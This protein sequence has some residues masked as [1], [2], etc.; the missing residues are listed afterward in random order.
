MAGEIL[1]FDTPEFI[2][3]TAHGFL[4]SEPVLNNLILTLL[5][6]RIAFPEPVRYW[7]ARSDSAVTGVGLQSPPSFALIL[8]VMA[9]EVSADLAEAIAVEGRALPGVLADARVAARFAGQW[10]ECR[11]VGVQPV[12]AQRL[13]VAEAVRAGAAVPGALEQ[14]GPDARPLL[15]NWMAAFYDELGDAAGGVTGDIKDIVDRRVAA[16]EFWLW[17]DC[18]ST[19]M[20][21]IAG[22]TRVHYV[23]TPPQ[24]RRKGYAEA[25]VRT[26]TARLLGEG[27]QPILFTDPG[28]PA[29]NAI[30]RRVGYKPA[31]DLVRYRFDTKVK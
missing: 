13:Y 8:S 5:A 30:Y 2:N 20:A 1:S 29:S 16:G 4:V 15:C 23:Y 9:P 18:E 3:K 22:V 17:R 27:L 24:Y 11:S 31:A 25:L 14:A 12:I 7:I 28:N 26:P 19:A 21:A 6:A 10:A